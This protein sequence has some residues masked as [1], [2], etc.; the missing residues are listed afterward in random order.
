MVFSQNKKDNHQQCLEEVYAP[1]MWQDF[2][3]I[4]G[5]GSRRLSQVTSLWRRTQLKASAY[6]WG[7][8]QCCADLPSLK[9]WTFPSVYHSLK[10]FSTDT[11]CGRAAWQPCTATLAHAAFLWRFVLWER[12]RHADSSRF[13]FGVALGLCSPSARRKK[14]T[15]RAWRSALKLTPDKQNRE[16]SFWFLSLLLFNCYTVL[17]SGWQTWCFLIH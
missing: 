2:H 4:P 12:Q 16:D 7:A 11:V 5:L 9:P 6:T 14:E 15:W 8:V 13:F 3:F 1:V 17:S 10:S